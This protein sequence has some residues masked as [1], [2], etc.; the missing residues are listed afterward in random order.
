MVPIEAAIRQTQM[1]AA[2]NTSRDIALS[3]LPPR[4][5]LYALQDFVSAPPS[6]LD[7]QS[8]GYSFRIAIS[9][10]RTVMTDVLSVPV[11]L[12]DGRE[13][14]LD[15]YRGK[16]VLVVNVASKCGLTVQYEG[17]EKLYEDKRER[18]F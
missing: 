15:E 6:A 7:K 2:K 16:V 8:S 17:L 12:A 9:Y 13:T 4:W 3:P 1:K 5:K 14:T 11:K 18:G 10:W